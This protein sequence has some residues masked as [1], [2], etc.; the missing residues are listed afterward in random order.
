MI[1]HC[2]RTKNTLKKMKHLLLD[3]AN[4]VNI[5]TIKHLAHKIANIV[6]LDVGHENKHHR[7]IKRQHM[8]MIAP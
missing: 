4:I 8:I 1:V 5:K 3:V 7:S 6:N 2:Y